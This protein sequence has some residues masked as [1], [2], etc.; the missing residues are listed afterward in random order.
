MEALL[1]DEEDR[2]IT[3][4]GPPGSGSGGR[5]CFGRGAE[6]SACGRCRG[7]PVRAVSPVRPHDLR[8]VSESSAGVVRDVPR[9]SVRMFGKVVGKQG[10]REIVIVQAPAA[11]LLDRS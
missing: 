11:Q 7:I 10:L 4:L 3:V 6:S 5:S 1:L 2:A 8:G 9:R